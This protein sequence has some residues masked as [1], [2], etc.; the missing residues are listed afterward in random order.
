M[1]D[2]SVIL[3]LIIFCMFIYI[4]HLHTK[5]ALYKSRFEIYEDKIKYIENIL[6][7]NA[8]S[9]PDL[10]KIANKSKNYITTE[11]LNLAINYRKLNHEQKEEINS[12]VLSY[13]PED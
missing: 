13:I 2:L 3:A 8:Y 12:K 1:N 9:E 7:V 11:E 4:A 10:K 5:I 6:G